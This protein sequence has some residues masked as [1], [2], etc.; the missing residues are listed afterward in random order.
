MGVLHGR[1]SGSQC[2]RRPGLIG[3]KFQRAPDRPRTGSSL[4][5]RNRQCEPGNRLPR[6]NHRR[7]WSQ[8]HA[9]QRKEA[10]R[11]RGTP[12]KRHAIE[13]ELPGLWPLH[14]SQ[15]PIG[16]GAGPAHIDCA[17]PILLRTGGRLLHEADAFYFTIPRHLNGND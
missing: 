10:R 15:Q 16:K 11:R 7:R 12:H 14:H 17:L 4:L 9:C 13:P 3:K 8:A 2:V 6:N 5:E 1:T